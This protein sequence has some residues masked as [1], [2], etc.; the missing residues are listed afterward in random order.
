MSVVPNLQYLGS[1]E[2][3]SGDIVLVSLHYVGGDPG[4]ER[5]GVQDGAVRHAAAFGLSEI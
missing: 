3:L 1:T 4:Q 5:H 2:S